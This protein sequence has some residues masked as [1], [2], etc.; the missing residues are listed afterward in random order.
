MSFTHFAAVMALPWL[1]VIAVEWLGIRLHFAREIGARASGEPPPDLEPLPRAPLAVLGGTLAGFVLSAPL[2]YDPAWAAVAGAAAMVA[3]RPAP[4]AAL[5]R[6]IDLPLL[7]FV[8]G[9]AIIVHVVAGHGAGA[10]VADIL[11]DG[12]GLAALLGV[13]AIAAVAANLLNNVPAVLVLLPAAAAAGPATVLAV[14][15]GVNVAP[16]PHAHRLAGHAPPAPLAGRARR[17]AP[18]RRVRAP[19][20]AH[21][22][23]RDRPRHGRA[24]A[25]R[26]GNRRT[27]AGVTPV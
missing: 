14:L 6:A 19:R 27:A 1:V 3:V 26:V 7:G 10:L 24:L 25:R 12:D 9:L 18:G 15:I 23:A 22:A 4:L 21:R 5:V 11:P 2:G 20:R 16:Q 17:R 13:A 8:L